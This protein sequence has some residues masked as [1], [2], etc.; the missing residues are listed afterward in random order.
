MLH[1]E[2]EPR[3]L[4]RRVPLGT[5]LDQH[6][7]RTY[8]GLV[9][10]TFAKPRVFGVPI[11]FHGS[12]EE[13]HL[14]FYVKHAANGASKRGAVF[15]RQICSRSLVSFA[16]RSFYNEPYCT[17][18]TGQRIEESGAP[19][20]ARAVAYTWRI[21]GR[22][23]R[24]GLEL[25]SEPQDAPPGSLEDFLTD[26]PWGYNLGRDYVTSEVLVGHPRWKVARATRGELSC[27]VEPLF[28]REFV[29]T[30]N[31]VPDHVCM[32]DGSPVEIHR[33]RPLA[34]Y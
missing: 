16:A 2:V 10:F 11:P 4:E 7:G 13:I 3:I 25:A 30:L 29:A 8:I 21:D 31:R 9:G 22:T 17:H 5:E 34:Q 14:R 26:R 6:D 19:S 1:W 27:D 20:R 12:F 33:R 32:C 15:V 28:G 24:M 23:E 18:F